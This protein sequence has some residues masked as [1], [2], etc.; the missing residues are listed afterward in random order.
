M[1][2][3]FVKAPIA[4]R[5]ILLHRTL[6]GLPTGRSFFQRRISWCSKALI[7]TSLIDM[8][9]RLSKCLEPQDSTTVDIPCDVD[10]KRVD[11]YAA[12][13]AYHRTDRPS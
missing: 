10:E 5:P 8:V 2:A 9:P 1:D 11:V 4:T 6:S 13:F 12:L 7:G 3:S